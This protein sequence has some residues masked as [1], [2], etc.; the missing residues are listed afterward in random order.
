MSIAIID[1][2]VFFV[3][4][5][6]AYA[7]VS[8]GLRAVPQSMIVA[9]MVQ[10]LFLIPLYTITIII[11]ASVMVEFSQASGLSSSEAVNWLPISATEFVVA[12][13]T[14]TVYTFSFVPAIALGLALPP[15][16]IS[17][18]ASAWVYTVLVVLVAS[19]TGAFFVEVIRAGINRVS[20]TVYRRG[21]RSTIIIRMVLI[22][23]LIALFQV[24]FNP[25]ILFALFSM[26]TVEEAWFVP[27][28][29]PSLSIIAFTESNYMNVISNGLL[30]IGLTLILVETGVSLRARYWVPT[31]VS[32]RVTRAAYAPRTG[33]LSGLGFSSAESAIVRKDLKGM[34]R[35]TEMIRFLAVPVVMLLPTLL[36]ASMA[37]SSTVMGYQLLFLTLFGMFFF[38]SFLSMV[39]IGQ[40]GKAFW[41][42]SASPIDPK[43][44]VKAKSFATLVVA[45]TVTVLLG[46]LSVVLGVAQDLLISV[47]ASAPLIVLEETFIGLAVGATYPDFQ[48][49]PR[50]RFVT[51]QGYVIGM[52]V[53]GLAALATSLP[54]I[55][56]R[57][58]GGTF[59]LS[60][61]LIVTT[62]IGATIS[63]IAYR[64]ALSRVNR[65]LE[66]QPL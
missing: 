2:V 21:G 34:T 50:A 64:W 7:F 19:F 49:V 18:L 62:A 52:V 32:I 57:F 36:T 46:V 24:M 27:I 37:R 23:V 35:R 40:E 8:L 38:P 20:F 48:E 22:I 28:L 55:S 54:I 59:Q 45:L 6:I 1:A 53:G 42:L 14:A 4:S 61:T 3:S 17:G 66:E 41:N 63:L 51:P 11:V 33:I 9:G 16:I 31:P 65:L 47:F 25:S 29:W 26:T 58:L 15:T 30:T 44:L 5:A 12:S 60:A 39:S 10:G 56:F 13:S 43:G